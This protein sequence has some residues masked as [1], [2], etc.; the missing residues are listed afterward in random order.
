[1]ILFQCIWVHAGERH[2]A[3]THVVKN[4][5][6]VR[7]IAVAYE[8]MDSLRTMRRIKGGPTNST[9]LS[10]DDEEDM[11]DDAFVRA[12][13]LCFTQ[14]GLCKHLDVGMK[15][16]LRPDFSVKLSLLPTDP[17][18]LADAPSYRPIADSTTVA[19][20]DAAAVNSFDA[21]VVNSTRTTAV[22][23]SSADAS[24]KT[25]TE[26]SGVHC[27]ASTGVD[28]FEVAHRRDVQ[29][30]SSS[31]ASPLDLE[32]FRKSLRNAR[33]DSRKDEDK[34]HEMEVE[35]VKVEDSLAVTQGSK[36]QRRRK[37]SKSKDTVV[38]GQTVADTRVDDQDGYDGGMA[39]D[40][41]HSQDGYQG[42]V[43]DGQDGK[44][45]GPADEYGDG[46]D[47]KV[48]NKVSAGKARAKAK[49]KA[50][51]KP[52]AATKA[53][54]GDETAG[55]EC[56]PTSAFESSQFHGMVT[57]GKTSGTKKGA[58]ALRDDEESEHGT[59]SVSSPMTKT[60]VKTHGTSDAESESDEDVGPI[61]MNRYE[62]QPANPYHPVWTQDWHNQPPTKDMWV[63]EFEK[64][65]GKPYVAQHM[66]AILATHKACYYNDPY[67]LGFGDRPLSCLIF[68]HHDGYKV[69]SVE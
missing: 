21:L 7:A 59:G 62:I 32:A 9:R 44:V 1:M 14:F 33:V 16:F 69:S 51:P 49:A 46:Q 12:N 63:A 26:S 10:F 25:Q 2:F 67:F 64:R 54:A 5:G 28:N 55:T 41:G 29:I 39:A 31:N 48:G 30:V 18:P 19:P 34:A 57:R 47:G 50:K 45:G 43:V 66:A 4:A 56:S 37:I 61:P 35:E 13:A 52:K 6:K 38:K 27:S 11:F 68:P 17:S 42:G 23:S 60:K 53:K 58:V 65:K 24:V 15:V 8:I 36:K 20:A 40:N 22:T 3:S